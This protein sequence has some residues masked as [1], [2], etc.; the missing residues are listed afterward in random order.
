MR[1]GLLAALFLVVLSTVAAHAQQAPKPLQQCPDDFSTFKDEPDPVACFCPSEATRAGSV[2]GTDTYTADSVICRAALHAGIVSR[3]GGAVSVTSQ[4]GRRSY[5]GTTRNGV[6]SSN[7]GPYDA[8]FSFDAGQAAAAPAA[9]ATAQAAPIQQ[10]PDDFAAFKEEPDALVCACPAEATQQGSVWGTDI[11]TADSGLCRAAVHAGMISRRGGQVTVR[12]EPGRRA[13]PGTTRNGIASSNY[14]QFEASFRFEGVPQAP[15][16]QAAASA[17]PAVPQQ[18]PD[19]FGAFKEETDPVVCTCSADATQRGS[20]WGSDVYTSDSG[21]C[22]AA[23]HA[24]LIPRA[25]GT[26]TVL[27]EPGRRTYAGVTRNGVTSSN[28]GQYEA[29]F[30]FQGS[31]IQRAAPAASPGVPQQCPDNFVAFKD[32]PDPLVCICPAESTRIGSLWGTDVYTADS[33]LCLAALHAGAIGRLGGQVSVTAE[34]GRRA[35]PGTTRN[36]LTSSN[37]GPYDASFR[38]AGTGPKLTAPVQASIGQSLKA[39]GRVN[40]Y[41]QFRTGS[42]DLDISAAPVLAELLAVLQQDPAMRLRL[43]GHTDTAGTRATNAPLSV[44][45]ADAVRTWLA[46]QGIDPARLATDG[47]GQDEPIAPNTTEEGKALNR[48]VQAARSN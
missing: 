10:C 39:S 1:N 12:G 17:A 19:D 3:R 47:R 5:Y 9:P 41:I 18:C 32:E 40:L 30:R 28:Y 42:A 11:Y 24:G 48:R 25:G 31:P 21:L 13:Y 20:V 34:P 7:Y 16:P 38:I 33:G 44:R 29:S 35:Y 46:S 14:G 22:R 2:W 43:T 23:L 15:S 27:A 6:T 37:Y 4:P 8:S 26:V 36:G 45:R